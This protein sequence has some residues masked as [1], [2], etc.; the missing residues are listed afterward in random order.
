MIK[1]KCQSIDVQFNFIKPFLPFRTNVVCSLMYFGSVKIIANNMNTDQIAPLGVACIVF[2]SMIKQKYLCSLNCI[3][4]YAA[5]A[6]IP[7]GH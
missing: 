6:F 4:L 3:R 1:G 5:A 2:P 7:L